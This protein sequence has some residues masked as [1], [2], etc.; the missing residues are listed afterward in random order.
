MCRCW[1]SPGLICLS[2]RLSNTVPD[3]PC[4]HDGSFATPRDVNRHYSE[5]NE[6]RPH[7]DGQR[8]LKPLQLS[9]QEPSDLAGITREHFHLQLALARQQRLR[10]QAC[11]LRENCC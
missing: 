11:L 7:A 3:A 1:P 2:V 9:A 4:M 8:I 6:E 5:L 10:R